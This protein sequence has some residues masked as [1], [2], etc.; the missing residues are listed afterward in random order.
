MTRTEREILD[1]FEARGLRAGD[2]YPL[3]EFCAAVDFDGEPKRSE[4]KR[5]AFSSLVREGHIIEHNAAV[6]LTPNGYEQIHR[7]QEDHRPD[8]VMTVREVAAYFRVNQR[9]VYNLASAGK[10]PAIKIGKQWRFRKAEIEKLF[11]KV[12][13]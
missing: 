7:R 5:Q 11:E 12:G 13:G 4:E 3:W 9:T 8:E 10:L 2:L 6:E 1:L